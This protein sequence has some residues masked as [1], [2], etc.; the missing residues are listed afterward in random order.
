M[1]NERDFRCVENVFFFFQSTDSLNRRA[2]QSA[3]GV[4]YM[5]GNC[6][7]NLAENSNP[8]ALHKHPCRPDRRKPR[9]SLATMGQM[10]TPPLS[11]K[12]FNSP[13]GDDHQS[14][15]SSMG[16]IPGE[17]I[18]PTEGFLA[19]GSRRSSGT[20]SSISPSD[21][22]TTSSRSPPAPD[23]DTH[24]TPPFCVDTDLQ[25][26]ISPYYLT[27][28]FS[29]CKMWKVIWED[30]PHPEYP[31]PNPVAT[32]WKCGV[33]ARIEIYNP[34]SEGYETIDIP[35]S[36]HGVI[37]VDCPC[38]GSCFKLQFLPIGDGSTS[39]LTCTNISRPPTSD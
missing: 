4:L 11:L 19:Q 10:L 30:N 36:I 17:D 15:R 31:Y 27:C 18:Y 6:V 5:T 29:Y 9:A 7:E 14:P 33:S 22:Y 34:F 12:E 8:R 25:S 1:P 20:V 24:Y 32:C 23:Y 38:G 28:P 35:P 21:G 2:V 13:A 37:D 3:P 39:T 26:T 16:A